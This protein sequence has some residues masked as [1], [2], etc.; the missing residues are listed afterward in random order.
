MTPR[1]YWPLLALWI[2]FAAAVFA[3]DGDNPVAPVSCA[4]FVGALTTSIATTPTTTTNN[5]NNSPVRCSLPRRQVLPDQYTLL[6]ES[7][8]ANPP[9]TIEGAL[10][11]DWTNRTQ[12]SSMSACLAGQGLLSVRVCFLRFL[13]TF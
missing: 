5:N 9:Y 8:N 13:G 7:T 6:F 11:Y 4:R 12:T 2:V 3:M 10:Y 1:P